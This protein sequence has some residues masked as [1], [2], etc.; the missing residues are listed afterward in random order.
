MFAKRQASHDRLRNLSKKQKKKRKTQEKIKIVPIFAIFCHI[1][2]Q[3][4]IYIHK[5]VT[6]CN[7]KFDLAEGF[8]SIPI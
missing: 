8:F 4:M 3:K 1:S 5:T 7:R 6:N 2:Q